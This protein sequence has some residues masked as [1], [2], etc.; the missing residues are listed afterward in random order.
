MKKMKKNLTI[1]RSLLKSVRPAVSL[2][3]AL[4]ALLL[5][6]L[7]ALQ[8]AEPASAANKPNILFIAIDDLRPELGCYGAAQ[9]KSPNIDKLAGQ[10]L[11]FDR[12]YCQVP[13]CGASRASLMAK[14]QNPS[15]SVP[16][17]RLHHIL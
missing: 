6:P 7:V 3:A 5:A 1:A 15:A 2:R 10:G 12:A 13:V 14:R 4:T 11:R 17:S 16:G 8:G 9:V